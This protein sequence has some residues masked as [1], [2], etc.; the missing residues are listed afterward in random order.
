MYEPR[1]EKTTTALREVKGQINIAWEGTWSVV[2]LILAFVPHALFGAG[3]GRK[4]CRNSVEGAAS[5]C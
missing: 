2:G 3:A 1:D 5:G 4:W